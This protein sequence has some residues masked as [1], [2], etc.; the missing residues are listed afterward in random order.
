MDENSRA[1]LADKDQLSRIKVLAYRLQLA[2]NTARL[3]PDNA[4]V[5]EQ[6]AALQKLANAMAPLLR[7]RVYM[8]VVVDAASDIQP[9][10]PPPKTIERTYHA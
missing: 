9:T 8:S 6:E 2:A 1:I 7:S 4:P 10:S 5:Q 3:L